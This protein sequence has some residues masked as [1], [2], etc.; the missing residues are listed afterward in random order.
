MKKIKNS[1]KIILFMWLIMVF[2]A[3]SFALDERAGTTGAQSLKIPLGV[4]SIAMG[5]AFCAIGEDINSIYWNPAGISKITG[6]ELYFSYNSW[7]LDTNYTYFSYARSLGEAGAG[8]IG[9][10]YVNMGNFVG[11]DNNGNSTGDFTAYDL[12]MNL[13]FAKKLSANFSA[14]LNTK[15]IY[16]K[17]ENETAF[18]FCFDIGATYSFLPKMTA[19]VSIQNLGP[20]FNYSNG[21]EAN[22]LPLNIK[23]GL[24]YK[25]FDKFLL[26][27]DLNIPNDD[28]VNFRLG[29]EYWVVENFALRL[30]YKTDKITTLGALSGLTTGVGFKWKNYLFDF[31]FVPYTDLGNTY[32]VSLQL[33]F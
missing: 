30:G 27:A 29:S 9:I 8:S 17:L 14:G 31:A 13:S 28:F 10:N 4:R 25:P 22:L 12:I 24:G 3:T 5:E 33:N 21:S 15:L 19:G 16:S 7:L 11:M 23:I 20:Y 2:S 6:Q 26:A 18:D 32:R 1:I